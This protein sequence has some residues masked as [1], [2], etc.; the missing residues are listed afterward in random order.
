MGPL[1]TRGCFDDIGERNI[2]QTKPAVIT[3]VLQKL[4]KTICRTCCKQIFME[5]ESIPFF[6]E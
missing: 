1:E 4:D 6:E 3:G 5:C 2:F